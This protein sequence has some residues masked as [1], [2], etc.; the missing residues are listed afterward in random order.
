M[1]PIPF[2][3]RL[4]STAVQDGAGLDGLFSCR[5]GFGADGTGR[6]GAL[7]PTSKFASCPQIFLYAIRLAATSNNPT[8][9]QQPHVCSTPHI[10]SVFLKRKKSCQRDGLISAHHKELQQLENTLD[11]FVQSG[12]GTEIWGSQRIVLPSGSRTVG[13][14]NR[15]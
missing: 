9:S 13:V 7:Q 2:S 14:A 10:P 4:P 11:A 5:P 12:D 8:P 3:S 15:M 6:Q 1:P